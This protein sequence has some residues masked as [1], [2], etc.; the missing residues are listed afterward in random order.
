MSRDKQKS[1]HLLETAFITTP[2]NA[3]R[4]APTSPKSIGSGPLPT[5]MK[6]I[7]PPIII[8]V[9]VLKRSQYFGFVFEL[10]L[11]MYVI[12]RNDYSANLRRWSV[13]ELRSHAGAWERE[14]A[15]NTDKSPA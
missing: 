12:E 10:I 4:I 14:R 5:N 6:P 1:H 3:P 2:N 13:E 15:F 9:N 11:Q 8:P 7:V